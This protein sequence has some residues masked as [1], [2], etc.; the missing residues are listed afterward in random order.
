MQP[1]DVVRL[2]H[3][4]EAAEEAMAFGTGR[5]RE[6]LDTDRQLARAVQKSIEI[7]GEAAKRVSFDV[8]EA[9]PEVPWRAIAGMRDRTV[10][11]YFDIDLDVVWQTLQTELPPLARSLRTILD[12]ETG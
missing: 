10:H 5:T 2:R 9:H 3:M 11:R 8:R 6:D 12:R 7:V 1:T 4:L